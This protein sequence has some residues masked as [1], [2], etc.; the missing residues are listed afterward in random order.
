M[1]R[2]PCASAHPRPLD[3]ASDRR[4]HK[5]FRAPSM[6][7]VHLPRP[8]K[9]SSATVVVEKGS[10]S[11]L[12]FLFVTQVSRP[13]RKGFLMRTQKQIAASREN[14]PRTPSSSAPAPSRPQPT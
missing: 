7:Y 1:N 12:P 4:T 10:P 2:D 14:G 3:L 13:A 8:A 5:I 6:T 11:G 9:S